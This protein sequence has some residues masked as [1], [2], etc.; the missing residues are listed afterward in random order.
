MARN[1]VVCCD[2]TGNEIEGNLSNVL[3]LFRVARKSPQQRVYYNPGIG[4]IGHRDPWA[5]FKQS[6][7][8]AFGLATGYGID[9][10]ILEAYRF[11][12]THWENGD[13]IFLFGFSRGAYTV[14]AVAGL[15]HLL[16]LLAPDQLNLATYALNAYKSASEKDDLSIAWNFRRIVG[17]R[18]TAIEF[19]GVWDT[20]AS[21][22]VPRRDR[23]LPSL[24]TLPYTRRNPSVKA[25]RHAMAIDE[26]RRMFR[27]NHW[28]EPQPFIANPF[29]KERA[30][31]PQDVKQ[32][33]FA[34]VH[35]DI[36]GGYPEEES[37]LSKFPLLWM[38]DQAAQFGL[39]VN[40]V[41]RRRIAL[42]DG[43][44]HGRIQYI[45]PDA[46]APMHESL[47]GGWHAMEWLPKS[48]RWRE[49]QRRRLFGMYLPRGEPRAMM[50]HT[51]QDGVEITGEVPRVH[52][53][54]I[55]RMQALPGYR[56]VN[57]P[58]K[59]VVEA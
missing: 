36:G 44:K 16:G 22:I 19:I 20:V 53:S 54:V 26:R 15:I 11:I 1:L 40:S 30:A 7:R 46:S 58:E 24:Q 17:A 32:V 10:D 41:S 25:F 55:E 3:K 52:H 49:W 35:S 31:L 27:V 45:E 9:H 18:R 37:G 56:P 2:G 14:R 38:L 39:K 4:T 28:L 23:L 50:A 6:A 29:R 12:C 42:G 48:A 8:A 34:G 13:A 57:L 59:Y 33:W 5:H 43:N 51:S 21:V 47:E